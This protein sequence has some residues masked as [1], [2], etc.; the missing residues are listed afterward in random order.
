MIFD[1]KII[2]S[3]DLF[4]ITLIAEYDPKGDFL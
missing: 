1:M 2:L 3:M 4:L